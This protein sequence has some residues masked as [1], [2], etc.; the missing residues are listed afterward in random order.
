MQKILSILSSKPHNLHYLNRYVKFIKWCNSQPKAKTY[1]ES[2]HIC[3]KAADLFPEYKDLRINKW[4][5]IKLTARQHII[6]HIILWKTYGGS[7]S[8]ALHYILNIQNE[9]TKYSTRS[10][11]KSI[12]IRYAAKL[13]DEFRQWRKEKATFKDASGKKYFLETTDPLIQELNLVGFMKDSVQ[14]DLHKQRHSDAKKPNRSIKLYFLS[15][16]TTVK[17]YSEDFH[18][19]I[20]QGWKSYRNT[21]DYEFIRKAGNA[22]TT[23]FWTGRNRYATQDGVY[24]GSYLKNDPIIKEYD[25]IIYR[26]EKQIT[27]NASRSALATKARLGTNIY[28]NGIDEVFAF[29]P[30]DTTWKLGRKPR[31]AEWEIKRKEAYMKACKGAKTY[32]NGFVNTFIKEG[33]SIPDGFYLGMKF[34][35]NTIYYYTNEDETELL[36]FKGHHMPPMGMTKIKINKAM[37]IKKSLNNL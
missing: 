35:P 15:S 7:Q 14:S 5:S 2:H 30:P 4:N 23:V 22:K 36:E 8:Q 10:V 9:E 27:Q 13:K 21:E 37:S 3:P 12:D 18:N 33:D 24:F 34:R 32:T 19:Y 1:C 31:N 17:L 29:E 11:P 6:A 20:E 16:K 25:L 28:T 26:S